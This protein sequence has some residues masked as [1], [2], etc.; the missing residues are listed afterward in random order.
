VRATLFTCILFSFSLTNRAQ[1]PTLKAWDSRFGGLKNEYLYCL[2]NTRDSGIVLGGV[3]ESDSSGDVSQ[4]SRGLTDFWIVKTDFDGNM[5][6]EKRFG[7]TRDDLLADVH[8]TS[9][10]GYILGGTIESDSSGDVSQRKK[11]YNDYWIVK[12]DAVGNKQWDKRFGGNSGSSLNAITSTL[13]VVK[14]TSD[15]GYIIGGTTNSDSSL[16]VSQP[17]R[18]GNDYWIIK[19]D[20]LGNKQ[21]D[22]RFGGARGDDLGYLEIAADGG[23]VLVGTSTSGIGGD[24]SQSNRDSTLNTGD[25]WIVKTDSLGNLQWDRRYGGVSWEISSW[26]EITRDNGF[27]LGGYTSSDSSYDVSEH[28]RG[29]TDFW[30]VKI[31]SAGNK[32]WDVRYGGLV[33]QDS[34]GDVHGT[35]DGGYIV[36]GVAYGAA[37]GDKTESNYLGAEQIWV[38]KMDS[39]GHK[40][41]D[42]T[43]FDPAHDEEGFVIESAD[44]CYLAANNTWGGVGG[45]KSQNARGANDF[46]LVKMC[47]TTHFFAAYDMSNVICDSGCTTFTNTSQHAT[48]YQWLF[49]GGTPSSSGIVTGV[50]VCYHAIGVYYAT[51]IA[52]NANG[53]TD[54]FTRQI[55]V[56]PAPVVTLTT[57][58]TI[59]C[60][61]APALLTLSGAYANY[62]WGNFNGI[63]SF[64]YASQSGIYNATV[65]DDNGCTGVSNSV[66]IQAF[67]PDS[68]FITLSAQTICSNDSVMLCATPGFTN[69]SWTPTSQTTNCIYTTTPGIYSLRAYDIHGCRCDNWNTV[70]L[71]AA[72]APVCT[73]ANPNPP[74]CLHDTVSI[75]AAT[76]FAHYLWNNGFTGACIAITDTGIYFVTVTDTNGC[77][78]ISN[79]LTTSFLP[80]PNVIATASPPSI[81][82][83]DT[84]LI[85]ANPGFVSYRWSTGENAPCFITRLAGS[86]HVIVTDSNGCTAQSNQVA[87]SVYV[88]SPAIISQHGDTLIVSNGVSYQWYLNHQP[89][90][91]ATTDTF[92]WHQ[93]GLYTVIVTD[94]NGCPE[95]SNRVDITGIDAIPDGRVIL[96]PNP[97]TESFH[98][99]VSEELLGAEME[100]TDADG[101]LVYKSV[102]QNAYSQIYWNAVPGTY[103]FRI[104]VPGKT[105][106]RKLVKL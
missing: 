78:A 8:Q 99:I 66:T 93:A 59:I 72:A 86:Y 42:K 89:I 106:L 32:K 90:T 83:K 14:Q 81:C 68:L 12:V 87:V 16:D 71:S 55:T 54:T 52:Y 58:A 26:I 85:C 50:Q 103:L 74:V 49:P 101:R 91:G 70:I 82:D 60:T 63:D 24:K 13:S 36:S 43:F 11:G 35:S 98:L 1:Q 96:Y 3:T 65:T 25:Y 17:T 19:T 95:T 40:M 62:N 56:T 38:V 100:V 73:I 28:A 102:I 2:I 80:V 77:S 39:L 18:G 79:Q 44:K 104:N 4:P 6:W 75:C 53:Q 67:T 23:F 57:S 46:W 61:N 20:A 76:G 45:L 9:D 27:V 30:V 94:S 33:G 69:F 88:T 51:L 84:S 64:R 47:D 21:W 5:Q 10:G 97:S 31:D 37:G 34:Y 41:W 29:S 15:G 105:I 7:G 92:V 48:H 22:K